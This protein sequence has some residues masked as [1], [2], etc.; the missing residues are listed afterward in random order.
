MKS[1]KNCF[2]FLQIVFDFEQCVHEQLGF[3]KCMWCS[4]PCQDGR[5]VMTPGDGMGVGPVRPQNRP[6]KKQ[7]EGFL[8]WSVGAQ[9]FACSLRCFLFRFA[10]ASLSPFPFSPKCVCCLQLPIVHGLS[11]DYPIVEFV[12]D[13]QAT[14]N[15]RYFS[16]F[17]CWNP[18]FWAVIATRN[19]KP[20]IAELFSFYFPLDFNLSGKLCRERERVCYG[21]IWM[22]WILFAGLKFIVGS[23][24]K[25]RGEAV[26]K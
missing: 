22:W 5:R 18:V 3:V 13:K 23:L 24:E 17:S 26:G 21:W 14:E 1:E 15:F 20:T 10:F 19:W 4:W 12:H 8:G 11:R 25:K 6:D 16:T 9:G 7:G 2:F